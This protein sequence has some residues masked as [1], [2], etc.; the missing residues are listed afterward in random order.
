MYQGTASALINGNYPGDQTIIKS[1]VVLTN[2]NQNIFTIN[3]I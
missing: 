3:R 1:T 2:I